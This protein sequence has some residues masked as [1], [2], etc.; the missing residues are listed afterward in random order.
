MVRHA[1]TI[2]RPGGQSTPGCHTYLRQLTPTTPS[3]QLC[4]KQDKD[5]E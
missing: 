4:P 3:R 5:R 2:G 1:E